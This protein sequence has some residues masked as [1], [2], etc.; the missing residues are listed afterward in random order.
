MAELDTRDLLHD[1]VVVCKRH[2][3]LP[4]EVLSYNRT[5]PVAA[6]RKEWF[7]W[8][9]SERGWGPSSIARM[10]GRDHSTVS[11]SIKASHK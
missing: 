8:L 4:E 3:V 11:L 2:G 9:S 1:F 7:A 6:A 5:K 10:M